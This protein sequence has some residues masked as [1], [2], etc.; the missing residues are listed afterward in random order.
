MSIVNII[1]DHPL[2]SPSLRAKTKEVLW[3]LS[4]LA[5]HAPT[6][7][8]AGAED[9]CSSAGNAKHRVMVENILEGRGHKREKRPKERVKNIGLLLCLV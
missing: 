4:F 9:L 6:L 8:T 3:L 5:V 1:V 2:D 7:H